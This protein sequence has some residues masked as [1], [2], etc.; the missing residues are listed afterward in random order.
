MGAL[1]SL[2]TVFLPPAITRKVRHRDNISESSWAYKSAPK[3]S[4]TFLLN[5]FPE[6]Y[7]NQS[8]SLTPSEMMPADI[9]IVQGE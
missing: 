2:I 9:Y 1:C 6:I 3:S 7:Y 5:I 8:K 4:K